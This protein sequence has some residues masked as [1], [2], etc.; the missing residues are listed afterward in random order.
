MLRK[1]VIIIVLILALSSV[2]VIYTSFY[3]GDCLK[4][5][6]SGHESSFITLCPEGE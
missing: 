4:V 6:V 1:I 3:R 2:V 5:Y